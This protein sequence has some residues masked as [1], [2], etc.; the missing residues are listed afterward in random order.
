MAQTGSAPRSHRGGQGFKSPQLH[1]I[2]ALTSDN[3]DQGLKFVYAIL[4]HPPNPPQTAGAATFVDG[5]GLPA[6]RDRQ[7]FIPAA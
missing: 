4:N 2:K 7:A 1:N 3:A 5:V 6:M